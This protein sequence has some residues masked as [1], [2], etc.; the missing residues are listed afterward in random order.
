MLNECVKKAPRL[1]GCEAAYYF[2]QDI[3]V[4]P[5]KTNA[6]SPQKQP[7]PTHHDILDNRD[8]A[9]GSQR[10]LVLNDGREGRYPSD[11]EDEQGGRG[12]GNLVIHVRSGDI[13][14]DRV[15]PYKGQVN[16]LKAS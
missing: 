6:S 16:A 12:A 7:G 15:M 9:S 10:S 4:C 5:A 3:A 1:R 11:L 14:F 13:F 8:A 2:P